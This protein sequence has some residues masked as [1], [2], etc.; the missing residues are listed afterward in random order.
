M[1]FHFSRFSPDFTHN[2]Y[3]IIVDTLSNS[4]AF[5]VSSL[6]FE[7]L[8]CF[9]DFGFSGLNCVFSLTRF[10]SS[11]GLLIDKSKNNTNPFF[12]F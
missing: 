11:N 5:L 8:E 1:L 3:L 6:D 7:G 10:L 12:T 4:I 2:K 9:E